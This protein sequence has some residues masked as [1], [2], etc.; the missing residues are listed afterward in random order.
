MQLSEDEIFKNFAKNCGHC[1]RKTLLPYQYEWSCISSGLNLI[2]RKHELAK[3][4]WKK[5][6]SVD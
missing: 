1:S 6:L 5:N 2:K 4:S 3:S